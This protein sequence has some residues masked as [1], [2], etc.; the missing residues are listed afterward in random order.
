MRYSKKMTGILLCLLPLIL[1]FLIFLFVFKLNAGRMFF[2]IVLSLI[3][4]FLISVVQYFVPEIPFFSQKPLLN[5]LLKSL[6]LYGF[7]EEFFKAFVM[8]FQ[9]LNVKLKKSD[10][11][12]EKQKIS[13]RDF[14][15]L[16]LFLGLSLGCFESIVYFFYHLQ[17][18]DSQGAEFLY[19][20]IL[21]RI[22]SSDLIHFFTGGLC[23]LFVFECKNHKI[24]ISYF[25]WAVFLHGFYD[26]FA[27]FENSFKI[28]SL[29]V[30]ILSAVE[31]RIKYISNFGEKQTE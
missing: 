23:G 6:V 2:S 16:S 14:L 4:I 9:P 28:F 31:C 21:I 26:F 27:L 20:K 8:F 13:V 19:G 7:V 12:F 18:A 30:I 5:S 29:A 25:L 10:G 1:A 15:F 3:S 17:I 22:F 11:N 24:K